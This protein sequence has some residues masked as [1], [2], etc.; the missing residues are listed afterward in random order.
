MNLKCKKKNAIWD[1]SHKS[2]LPK[3]LVLVHDLDKHEPEG[4]A[5]QQY[6]IVFIELFQLLQLYLHCF[7]ELIFRIQNI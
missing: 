7:D 4:D 6:M 2:I 5:S 3:S 1:Y